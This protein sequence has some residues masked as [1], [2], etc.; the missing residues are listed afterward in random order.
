MKRMRKL[1]ATG[2]T[3]GFVVALQSGCAGTSMV[4]QSAAKPDANPQREAEPADVSETRALSGRVT[5][6]MSAGGYTYVNLEKGGQKSWAAIPANIKAGVGEDLILKPGMVMTNFN[7]KALNRTF[8]T[9][10]FT[11]GPVNRSAVKTAEKTKRHGEISGQM[12]TEGTSGKL[13]GK[14]VETL[15]AGGY[16]Y[17][18]LEKGGKTA[19]VAIPVTTVTVGQEIEVRPGMQMGTFTS[20][21][22]NRTFEEIVFSAGLVTEAKPPLSTG[23][24]SMDAM[25]QNG[26]G[27]MDMMAQ[28]GKEMTA[29]SGTVV[30]TMDSAGYT[31]VCIEKAGKK[32]WAAAP[33]MKVSIGQELTLQPGMKM[34]NFKSA[35]LNRTFDSVIFSGGELPAAK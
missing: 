10:V 23:H 33:T 16:T 5:E 2:L 31:Y 20:K 22:L 26:T 21:T 27:H 35:N 19:W 17:V 6:T 12:A 7:S 4:T 34:I 13:A 24:P 8:D 30:E 15:D 11:D 18:N 29:V 1:L 3:L 9:I 28:P 14:V 32:V 25:P